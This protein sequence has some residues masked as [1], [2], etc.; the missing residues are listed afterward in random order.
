MKKREVVELKPYG[1]AQEIQEAALELFR[2]VKSRRIKPEVASAAVK[3]LKVADNQVKH[4][5]DRERTIVHAAK[6]TLEYEKIN[7]RRHPA[8]DLNGVVALP[9]ELT[10]GGAGGDTTTPKRRS[11]K[12]KSQPTSAAGAGAE[13]SGKSVETAA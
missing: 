8:I 2:D 12:F 13:T 4:Q 1:R 3:A 6:V 11:R 10:S 7:R 9:H 5:I